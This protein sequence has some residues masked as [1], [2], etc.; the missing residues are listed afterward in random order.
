MLDE[1]RRVLVTKFRHTDAEASE[2]VR[3]VEASATLV[4]ISGKLRVVVDDPEDD[5]F[6]ETAQRAGAAYIVSGDRHLLVLRTYA[7]ISVIGARTFLNMLSGDP[8]PVGG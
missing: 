6:V 2:A 1:L 4:Q 7:G 8:E 3:F 5:K